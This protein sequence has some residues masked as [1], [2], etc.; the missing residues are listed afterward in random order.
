MHL[1]LYIYEESEKKKPHLAIS[2]F[3]LT[4]TAYPTPNPGGLWYF[5]FLAKM[6]AKDDL[7]FSCSHFVMEISFLEDQKILKGIVNEG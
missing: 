2:P 7:Q 6:T 5:I 1:S 3:T 4:F